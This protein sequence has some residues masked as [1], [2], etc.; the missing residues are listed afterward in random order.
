MYLKSESQ[1]RFCSTWNCIGRSSTASARSLSTG[2]PR[3][4]RRTLPDSLVPIC[5]SEALSIGTSGR[6]V[7]TRRRSQSSTT[8][9]GKSAR[10]THAICRRLSSPG[11]SPSRN[12]RRMP[13]CARWRWGFRPSSWWMT[14]PQR[15]SASWKIGAR[16]RG[17]VRIWISS[18]STGRCSKGRL[19]WLSFSALSPV[20]AVLSDHWLMISVDT[21]LFLFSFSIKDLCFLCDRSSEDAHARRGVSVL[22]LVCTPTQCT[23][24]YTFCRQVSAL[25]FVSRCAALSAPICVTNFAAKSR[26]WN[27]W[28]DMDF[29]KLSQI[30]EFY[31][32]FQKKM[33]F[34]E[35]FFKIFFQ[36][37]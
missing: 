31:D 9:T 30:S 32:F 3:P 6:N 17:S 11:R 19:E 2:P 10:N 14:K 7:F 24:R 28:A 27:L 15:N 34:S 16:T 13:S 12:A 1:Y 22:Y 33:I 29:F 4:A 25:E 21:L 23:V 20:G 36:K 5:I 37:F 8:S 18:R 35:F 26:H